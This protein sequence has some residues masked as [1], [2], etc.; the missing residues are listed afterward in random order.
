MYTYSMNNVQKHK[1]IGERLESSV[2]VPPERSKHVRFTLVS[3][4]MVMKFLIDCF[5]KPNFE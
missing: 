2:P 1:K 3:G 4:L 5:I